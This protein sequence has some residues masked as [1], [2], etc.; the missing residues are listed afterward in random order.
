MRTAQNGN[1]RARRTRL[2]LAAAAAA[3]AV[4][5]L[6][7]TMPANASITNSA[8]RLAAAKKP[9]PAAAAHPPAT[10]QDTVQSLG[11]T[12]YQDAYAGMSVSSPTPETAVPSHI[13]IYVVARHAAPFLDAVRG[14]VARSARTSAG[15]PTSYS[16]VDVA[17]TW[18]Q[19]NAL[20]LTIAR[21]HQTW[22]DR[23][24]KLGMWGMGNPA[25]NKVTINLESY[26][27]AAARAL[28]AA[29]GAAWIS[30]STKPWDTTMYAGQSP[31]HL[32]ASPQASPNQG[33]F[34]D[35]SPFFG[36]DFI[37]NN[38]TNAACTDG[39]VMLGAIH[40]ANHWL[41]T[42][43]HCG[44]QQW[45]TNLGTPNPFA[46]T[47]TN[48]YSYFGG[49]TLYD[50]QTIG[51]TAGNSAQGVLWGTGFD[52]YYPY[53]TLTPGTDQ[54]VTFNGAISGEVHDI[55]VTTQGPVCENFVLTSGGGSIQACG[56]GIAGSSSGPVICQQADSG[57]P[58]YQRTSSGNKVQAV[59]LIVSS[60]ED[61]NICAYTLLNSIMG[62]TNTRL[63]TNTA[64]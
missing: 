50:V 59:G 41:M 61:G 29:Y 26:T 62:P 35:S 25:S 7:L 54:L 21:Q 19:L 6:S 42:A 49:S 11:A 8:A 28:Y 5:A 22:Q 4:A 47:A 17:H 33:K 13:T 55:P 57:G 37:F 1:R 64:G 24:I 51:L 23:G 15:A 45:F 18:S 30:V 58:V 53:T 39:F 14:T 60:N 31:R 36:G 16:I 43:G 20:T 48:Y 34:Q 10:L 56:L 40:P 63:D 32:D 12:T 46:N 38:N 44:N 9:V 52:T 3:I 27:P 2:S